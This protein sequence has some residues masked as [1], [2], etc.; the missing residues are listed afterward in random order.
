M[1]RKLAVG[2]GLVV[3]VFAYRGGAQLAITEV[4]SEAIGNT[5]T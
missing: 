4:M 2:V 1:M 3:G 5:N